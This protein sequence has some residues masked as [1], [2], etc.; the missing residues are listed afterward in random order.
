MVTVGTTFN[1]DTQSYDKKLFQKTYWVVSAHF[2]FFVLLPF[3]LERVQKT[4]FLV[5]HETTVLKLLIG[6]LVVQLLLTTVFIPSWVFLRFR[7]GIKRPRFVRAVLLAPV[8]TYFALIMCKWALNFELAPFV[9]TA[10]LLLTMWRINRFSVSIVSFVNQ[11]APIGIGV[12]VLVTAILAGTTI[13]S[14]SWS[15]HS[16]FLE[17]SSLQVPNVIWI[18]LDELGINSLLD[19]QGDIDARSYPAISRLKNRSTWYSNTVTPHTWTINAVPSM[20]TGDPKSTGASLPMDWLKKVPAGV[21]QFGYSDIGLPLC[22]QVTCQSADRMNATGLKIFFKDLA[23]VIGHKFLPNCHFT[24]FAINWYIVGAFWRGQ[25][26]ITNREMV[27][28][29]P[30]KSSINQCSLHDIRAHASF[31]SPVDL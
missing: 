12:A 9:V 8:V 10:L 30:T 24:F 3:T 28:R 5:I 2:W 23:I 25:A 11:L 16:S 17:D 29:R 1:M 4:A 13:P 7:N 14:V 22:T 18:V 15:S 20:L 31:S 6:Y 26:S 27:D 21:E 19:A